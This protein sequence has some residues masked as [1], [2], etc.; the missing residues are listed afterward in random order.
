M[1]CLI[2][3]QNSEKVA[4][5]TKVLKEITSEECTVEGIDAPSGFGETPLDE[6]TKRGAQNRAEYLS[7]KYQSDLYVGLE[8]GLVQRYGDTFEEAWCCIIKDSVQY[9]GYSS[10]LVI[11]KVLLRKMQQE[12]LEHFEALR[13]NEIR[14][15]LPIK[16][17]KDTW[18][19]YSA[20]M[21][22]RS[23]S[24]EEAFR[25][26]LVQIFAPSDSMYH[27]L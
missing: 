3:T 16:D 25:N 13:T 8:S 12:G 22:V 21:L 6:Q 27:R 23:I 7:K 10:G 9:L 26:C 2:G 15:L 4:S 11:P 24:F 20:Q 18:A 5:F 17:R 19:N 14:D 1:N